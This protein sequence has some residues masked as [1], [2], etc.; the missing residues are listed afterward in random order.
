[1]YEIRL[2]TPKTIE[3]SRALTYFDFV[4]NAKEIFEGKPRTVF[5]TPTGK[6]FM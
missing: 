3:R 1:M 5:G 4:R 6:P 2:E